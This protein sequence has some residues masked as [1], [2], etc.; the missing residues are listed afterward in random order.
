[1]AGL[2]YASILSAGRQLVPDLRQQLMQD[3]AAQMQREQFDWQRE[4]VEQARQAALVETREQEAYREQLEQALLS[5]KPQDVLRLMARFPKMAE[6]VKPVWEM[7]DKSRRQAELTAAGTIFSRAQAGDV[8]G[9]ASLLRERVEADRAAGQPDSADEAILTAL[10]S[11]DPVQV[12]AA[13]ATIGFGI[14]AMD[15]DKFS[16]TY[17]KL[18][19]QA[20]P[21]DLAKMLRE[22]GIE[23]GSPE[24]NEAFDLALEDKVNPL[25]Q[26][27]TSRGTNIIPRSQALGGGTQ[28]GGG[29]PSSTAVPATGSAIESAA[30]SAVPGAVVTSRARSPERNRAVGGTANS[31]HLTDQARDFVPPKGMS[32]GQLATRL[33]QAMPGFDVINEGDHVHVEPSSRGGPVQVRS[34][35][36]YDRLPAGTP[37]IAPDGSQRVKG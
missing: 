17:G 22:R 26:I 37:Y 6:S 35:Q 31:F 30:L 34:K 23:P 14:A 24:W 20:S 9:A 5:G 19:D 32:M 7:M 12:R 28:Q 29:G 8:D 21:T 2:D 27:Q 15:P 16:E 33:K 36:Q 18:N 1:M 10:E 25:I 4:R 13:I 3:E 11:R